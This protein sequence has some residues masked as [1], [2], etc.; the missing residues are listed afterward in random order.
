MGLVALLKNV[1]GL[2][3]T[4]RNNQVVV[5]T[6]CVCQDANIRG[7]IVNDQDPRA[8]ARSETI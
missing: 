7:F 3:G 8:A 1:H 5:L 6:E 2:G 4:G